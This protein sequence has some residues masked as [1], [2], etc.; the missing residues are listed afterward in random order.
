MKVKSYIDDDFRYLPQSIISE[1]EVMEMQ[2]VILTALKITEAVKLENNYSFICGYD[3]I[4]VG[5]DYKV[6]Q[7]L[8]FKIINKVEIPLMSFAIVEHKDFDTYIITKLHSKNI[9]KNHFYYTYKWFT[10]F[11]K[12]IYLALKDLQAHHFNSH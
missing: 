11:Q 7:C 12:K 5:T 6:V 9:P 10:W 3:D 1:N 2:Y 8:L 4:Y